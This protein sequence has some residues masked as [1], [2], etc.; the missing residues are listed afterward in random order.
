MQIWHA[1]RA[2]HSALQNGLETWSASPNAIR[3]INLC[4][5]TQQEVPH[6]M[7]LDEINLVIEQFRQGAVRAKNAGFDGIELHGAHGYL[8]D[9]FLR[10]SSNKRTDEYGGSY[11]NRCRLALQVIDHLIGIFGA[12]PVGMKI[13]PIGVYNDMNDTDPIPLYTYLL[14]ELD[15]RGVAYLELKEDQDEEN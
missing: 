4:A 3:G 7:T 12:K 1:G 5:Q 9:Q 6:E 10:N 13:T 8:I 15:K 2:S 11:E 14:K